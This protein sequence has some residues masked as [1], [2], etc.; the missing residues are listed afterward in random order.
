MTPVAGRLAISLEAETRRMHNE[1]F[2]KWH[3]IG[4]QR[5]TEIDNFRG[6]YIRYGGIKFSGTARLVYWDT[7]AFYLR[8]KISDLFDQVEEAI[9]DYPIELRPA[10]IAECQSL[11]S[12][13]TTMIKNAAIEKDQILRGDG[14]NFPP[15]DEHRR[16]DGADEVSIQSRADGLRSVY[17]VLQ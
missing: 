10:G 16:W 4:E 6:G 7:I 13:F 11:I 2:F 14:I 5:V 12:G 9:K 15:R 8:K 1:W 17:C 3:F